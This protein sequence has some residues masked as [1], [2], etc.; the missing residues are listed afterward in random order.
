VHGENGVQRQP[1]WYA[2]PGQPTAVAAVGAIRLR[3]RLI[4]YIYSYE[5]QRNKTGV[6]IVRPLL[7]DWPNDKNVR[8]DYN[9]WLFGEWLLVS[10]VVVQGQRNKDIYLPAGGWTEW[11]SGAA[12]Q[13]GQIVNYDTATW[14]DNI[15]LFFRAGAI[16]P[17][18][19]E[20][21]QYVGEK[22][23]K[24]L[25]VEVFPDTRRTSFDYYD[26]DGKT[27]DYEKNVYFLQTLSVQRTGNSVQFE[28][29]APDAAGSFKP[30][31]EYYTVKIHGPVSTSVKVNSTAM[32]Q[33]ANVST[34]TGTSEGWATGLDPLHGNIPVT[35]VRIKAQ[36]KQSVTLTAQ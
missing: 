21:V 3:Y 23:L 13:G 20:D 36:L 18:M 24:E 1:W 34:L 5:H 16:V 10:P 29:A 2:P 6:G 25:D 31:L 26:D 22:P 12:R 8:N 7:F 14:E 27:Y 28:T 4:P 35:Y 33:T 11:R 19:R 17:M 32:T 15:P 9:S 30:E